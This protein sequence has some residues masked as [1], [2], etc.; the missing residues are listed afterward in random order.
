MRYFLTASAFVV[1]LAIAAPIAFFGVLLLAGPH[2]GALPPAAG[3]WVLGAGWA[4]LIVVPAA[5]ARA[6][7]RRGS[8]ARAGERPR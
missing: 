1:A 6:V 3:P 4:L 5:V 7:W 2:G 8:R